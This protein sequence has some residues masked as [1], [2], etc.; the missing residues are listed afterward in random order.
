MEKKSVL[1]LISVIILATS[2][3]TVTYDMSEAEVKKRIETSQDP[4]SIFSF[5]KSSNCADCHRGYVDSM[6]DDKM[7]GSRH[8][9]AAEDCFT[10]HEESALKGAH[11]KVAR[12]P[13]KLFRQRKY[14]NE[15]CLRCHDDYDKLVEKTKDSKAF[16]TVDGKMVNPHDT[17]KGR[18]ECFNCHK[19]HKDKPPIEYCY[20]CH[21]ARQLNNC[22]DCHAPKKE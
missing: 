13:G 4:T 16:T 15:L 9:D 8:R 18:V 1:L 14:P 11:A 7:L 21:H 3:V 22:K 12:A 10:C 17:H 19:I 6:G 20:G 2:M 5:S